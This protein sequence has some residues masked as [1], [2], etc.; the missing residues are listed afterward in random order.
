MEIEGMTVAN[1]T[2][3]Y[4]TVAGSAVG[5]LAGVAVREREK[6]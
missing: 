2:P 6:D 4:R 5:S 3:Y 1:P